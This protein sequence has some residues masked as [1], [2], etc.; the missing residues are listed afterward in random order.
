MG[1][2]MLMYNLI[3]C[4]DTYSKT[5]V[6]LW[7]YYRDEPADVIVNSKSLKSKVKTIKT[8]E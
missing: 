6:S 3:E 5:S 8:I 1:V 7:H 2:V 4:K